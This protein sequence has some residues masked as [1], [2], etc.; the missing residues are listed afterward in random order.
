MIKR[1]MRSRIC[2][3]EMGT[4]FY[5]LVEFVV[6]LLY[7]GFPCNLLIVF[8]AFSSIYGYQIAD[9]FC[10]FFCYVGGSGDFQQGSNEN[11]PPS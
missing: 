11:F 10:M 6:S 5:S 8:P 7:V 4:S 9:S 3:E 2:T 1:K